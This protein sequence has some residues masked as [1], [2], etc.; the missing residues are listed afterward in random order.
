MGDSGDPQIGTVAWRDLTV[1][2]AEQ[3]RDIYQQVVG[4]EAVPLDMGGYSDFN[5]RPPGTPAPVAGICLVR[6]PNSDLPAQWLMY[7]VV[8]DVECSAA[9]V[10][11]LGGRVIS[12]PRSMDGARWCVIADPAGAVCALYQP[13]RT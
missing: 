11:R 9:D 7:I 4:W 8:A 10:V 12:G 2:D 6:G 13:Q 1:E 3:V 5:M